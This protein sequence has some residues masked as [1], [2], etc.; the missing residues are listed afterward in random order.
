MINNL[1]FPCCMLRFALLLRTGW[2]F[3]NT[4]SF[5]LRP[6]IHG[7]KDQHK[8]CTAHHGEPLLCPCLRTTCYFLVIFLGWVMLLHPQATI[9]DHSGP[10]TSDLSIE[11]RR[12]NHFT[13]SPLITFCPKQILFFLK[14]ICL[15]ATNMRLLSKEELVKNLPSPIKVTENRL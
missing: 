1:P 4:W 9:T 3:E 5:G 14:T 10:R 8:S 15:K 6:F 7:G 2:S 13:T 12:R 11:R